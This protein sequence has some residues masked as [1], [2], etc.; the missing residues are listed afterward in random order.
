MMVDFSADWCSACARLEKETFTDP[1]VA[2]EAKRFVCV[3]IDRSDTND[4]SGQRLQKQYGAIGLP[5]V[6]FVDSTGQF[7]PRISIAGFVKPDELLAR[8]RQVR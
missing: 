6:A 1:E 8:M 5:T 2:A 3:R 4:E 7:L